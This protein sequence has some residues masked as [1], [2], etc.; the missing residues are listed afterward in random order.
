MSLKVK[1][2]IVELPGLNFLSKDRINKF[3]KAYAVFII[4]TP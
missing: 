1:R 3:F 2:G 4:E